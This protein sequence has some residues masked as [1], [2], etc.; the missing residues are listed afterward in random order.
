MGAIGPALRTLDALQSLVACVTLQAPVS[1]FVLNDCAKSCLQRPPPWISHLLRTLG[2]V[3][4]TPRARAPF[5]PLRFDSCAF[6]K[7]G[8]SRALP[9]VHARLSCTTGVVQ[10]PCRWKHG[11]NFFTVGFC[12]GLAGGSCAFEWSQACETE[13][14]V[15]R[16]HIE[17]NVEKN[18]SLTLRTKMP[19]EHVDFVAHAAVIG[20]SPARTWW[21]HLGVWVHQAT[22]V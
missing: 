14:V 4:G 8:I 17:L 21:C 7:F 22:G 3:G 6:S 16:T 12:L 1:C 18:L 2:A 13:H 10:R 20:H 5:L 11:F 15:A 19:H 9:R